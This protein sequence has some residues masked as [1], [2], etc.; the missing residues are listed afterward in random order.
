MAFLADYSQF[1]GVH[2]ETGSIR[3]VLAHQGVIAPHTG[4]PLSEAMLLGV[5][6]GIVAGYFTFEYTGYEP[7]LHFLTRFTFDPMEVIFMR[8]DISARVKQTNNAEKGVANL[9]DALEAGKPALVWA[10]L[11]SLS[12]NNMPGSKDV[13]GM[14]P[15]VI[16]G[17]DGSAD[18]VHIADRS[19][20]PLTAT[21]SELAAARA[22][23]AQ[24]KHR[25]VTLGAPDLSRLPAAVEAGIR[26]CVSLFTDEPPKA[27][28]KGK[29]GLDA[30]TRWAALLTDTKSKAGWAKQFAPGARI[31][32]GLKSAFHYIN[33][34]GTDGEGARGLYADFLDEAGAVLDKPAL[35]E[36]AGQ[37]RT[38]AALWRALSHALLPDTVPLFEETRELMLREYTL[39]R[40]QGA[41]SLEKRR[42]IAA[43]L[44]AIKAEMASNFPLSDAEAAAFRENLRARVLAI[45]AAE[46][47]AVLA[48]RDVI[49]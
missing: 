37:F 16:Y 32:S 3:N 29:F 20:A 13:W 38:A 7:Y 1:G 10:D 43:R 12:Y 15:I 2:W 42:E 34:W 26:T 24:D 28:M 40:E 41:A 39:F 48:L 36:V 9:I 17:Y 23:V 4:K 46:Q 27:P 47:K 30:F 33:L 11:F 49:A 35:R 21:T 18:V 6:G 44:N 19:R 25:V 14:M 5:S 45:H 22:R 31:Y 8:L